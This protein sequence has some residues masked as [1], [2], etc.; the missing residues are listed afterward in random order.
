MLLNTPNIFIT[1]N[2]KKAKKKGKKRKKPQIKAELAID[3]KIKSGSIAPQGRDVAK[4]DVKISGDDSDK[5][6][7]DAKNQ[8]K[9]KRMQLVERGSGDRMQ[10]P[11]DGTMKAD[12][13][14]KMNQVADKGVL[15]PGQTVFQVQ[16]LSGKKP[17]E[18]YAIKH[19]GKDK[20]ELARDYLKKNPQAEDATEVQKLLQKDKQVHNV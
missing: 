8:I 11:E 7:E 20:M 19:E 18:M 2:K 6:S 16:G 13:P 5:I 9:K 12:S 15:A 17:F 14:M 1:I 10:I 3:P 4:F